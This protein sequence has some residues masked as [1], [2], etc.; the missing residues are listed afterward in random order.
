MSASRFATGGCPA[1]DDRRA[2]PP[3]YDD[4]SKRQSCVFPGTAGLGYEEQKFAKRSKKGQET[5]GGLT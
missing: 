2:V 1:C 4:G 5:L 3:A